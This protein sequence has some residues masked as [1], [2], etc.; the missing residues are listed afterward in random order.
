MHQPCRDSWWTRSVL[1]PCI[2][3]LSLHSLHLSIPQH[4]LF[5]VFLPYALVLGCYN[6]CLCRKVSTFL[7]PLLSY[8]NAFFL[9]TLASL[10]FCCVVFLVLNLR[11]VFLPV[12]VVWGVSWLL[13]YF[14][15]ISMECLVIDF[16]VVAAWHLDI[17][18]ANLSHSLFIKDFAM[19]FIT[20]KCV[21]WNILRPL[22]ASRFVIYSS[23][24]S[25]LG[26]IRMHE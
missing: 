15:I 2:F 24:T 4:H 25:V 3:D 22:P 10:K 9:S 8:P 1:V 16:L 5:L 20:F 26:F 6:E 19:D 21:T 14:V 17:S 23:S 11:I 18:L 12:W 7:F 13:W